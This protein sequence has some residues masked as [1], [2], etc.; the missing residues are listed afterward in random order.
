MSIA[1]ETGSVVATQDE[2]ISLSTLFSVTPGASDPTYLI[3]SGLDRNEYTAGYNT[4]D[5]GSLSG[6][7][8]TQNFTNVGSDAWSVG[9]VFTY[10]ASTG[11]YYNATYGYSDQLTFTAS[12]NTNDNVSLSVYTTNNY[13]LATEY[14]SNPYALE[15]DPRDFNYA[16]SVSVVT[17]PSDAGAAATQATPDSVCAAAQSFVGKAWN[18]DG[19]W[20]LTSNISAEA[21]AS[22]SASSTLV[23]VPGVGNGE[24]IVAYNGP[25]SANANWELNVTAGEMVGFVTT[26]G[27]GHI[28][29]VVSGSGTS[30]M[31]IDNVTYI[32]GNGSIMNAANDG[33]ANDIIV[34]APHAATQEFNGVNPSDVVVYELDTP[35][36]SDLVALLTVA[37]Q[38]SQSLASLFTASNPLASQ[39]ITAWQV[40][41]TNSNDS[42]TVGGV[43]QS[44]DHSAAAAATVTS[45]SAT[46]LLAGTV[47]GAD[48]IDVRAYNGTYWGDWQSLAVAVTGAALPAAPAAPT[49][50]DQTANQT[51]TQGQKVS[52]A[53]P[54][55]TFTDPQN[56]TLTY[57][58]RQSNGQA[59]PTWLSFNAATKTFSGTVP[60]GVASLTLRVTATDTNGLSN[61]ETFGVTVPAQ[62]P[63]V[64]GQTANQ[65]WLQGQKISLA[66]QAKTFTDPQ[67]QTLTYTASQSNGQALPSWLSF[68]AATKIF[69]GT[70]PTTGMESLII[71]VTATDASLVST[72]EIFGVTVPAAVAPIVTGQTENQ[73]WYQGQKI[74]LALQAKT[75]TDPQGETLT[76]AVSQSNGQALP[77]WLS[78]TAA[79]ETFSGTVPIGVESLTLKVTASNTSFLSGS[80]TFGVVVPAAAPAVTDQTASQNWTEGQKISLVL[81]ANTFTDPQNEALTYTASQSNGQALPSWLSFNAATRTFSGTV[82]ASTENLTV[83]LTATDTSHLSASET[84][85][86]TV[87]ASVGSLGA[88]TTGISS[89]GNT[90]T[91]SASNR[92]IDPGAGSYRMQFLPGTS[93]DT[94]VAHAG[95]SDEISGFNIGAGDV[96]DLRTLIAEMHL[97]PAT[98]AANIG[99][100][101]TVADQGAN[102]DVLFDPSGHHGGSLVAMLDNLGSTVTSLADL[103]LHGALKFS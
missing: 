56:Q 3:V 82:P 5:M 101:L 64:T 84:F 79:T 38:A 23:G 52:F 21:G 30:A 85:G 45:L 60:I 63:T 98:V 94:V 24:W 10:Q 62:A 75:F 80:E 15:Q 12:S 41:D 47:A 13:S 65:T 76:Y 14:A 29:T 61:A 100:Y 92:V 90:I 37:E 44:A 4:A 89:L 1:S 28:T 17:Q 81:P 20:V 99:A 103:T 86:V 72:T 42:I 96:L 9:I 2:R 73:T 31:L 32:N 6:G 87:P 95:G 66:L 83:K 49:V 16:G 50:T 7:G 53:L 26:A 58:A 91:I 40:Y 48:T 74:S 46:A 54:A 77:S 34:A 51:W 27:G 57:T 97:N 68:N 55:D 33:S 43:T 71:R 88:G 70:V 18:M 35:S 78:F 22:L 93:G 25:V 39:A 102:A 69:S 36:V 67:G 11:R 8:A 59:L 19:C